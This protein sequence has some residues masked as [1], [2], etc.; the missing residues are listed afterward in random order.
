M[1]IMLL[2]STGMTRNVAKGFYIGMKAS[3]GSQVAQNFLSA[4]LTCQ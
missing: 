1:D 3:I 4:S 2:V